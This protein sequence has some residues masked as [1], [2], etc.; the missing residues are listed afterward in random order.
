MKR[1]LFAVFFL[2][3]SFFFY[4]CSIEY[5][6]ANNYLDRHISPKQGTGIEEK[7]YVVLPTHVI[8]TNDAIN[9]IEGFQNL[10]E[11]EQD[12]LI[13]EKTKFL[14]KLNDSILIAQFNEH[15]LYNLGRFGIPIIITTPENIPQP[16]EGKI[17]TINVAQ[18]EAEEYTVVERLDSYFQ[19]IKNPNYPSDNRNTIQK[20]YKQ[21][22]NLDAFSLNVWFSYNEKDTSMKKVYYKSFEVRDGLEGD[23]ILN[24]ENNDKAEAIYKISKLNLND[25]YYT[26]FM[27]GKM[28]ATLFIE[29]WIN[30]Y[31][32]LSENGA[33]NYFFYD[34]KIN[35]IDGY[36]RK[37]DLNKKYLFQEL[38]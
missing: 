27:A 7:I 11:S 13:K 10:P 1:L 15:F 30:D 14:D 36:V 29:K 38:D 33:F 23:I 28:S 19:F 5:D 37:S 3:F 22:V 25:I 24:E 6:A 17:F 16:D 21:D 4:S 32:N 2:S 8:H 12:R 31:V 34:P 20:Y 18:M 35:K 26:P 9:K